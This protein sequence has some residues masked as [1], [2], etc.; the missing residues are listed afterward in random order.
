MMGKIAE[1]KLESYS[2]FV[3]YNTDSTLF[4]E[5]SGVRYELEQ[6]YYRFKK[7]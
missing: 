4:V 2:R 3:L 1:T 6:S 5:V 7:K